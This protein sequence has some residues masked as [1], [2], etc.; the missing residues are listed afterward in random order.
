MHTI[1]IATSLADACLH[2]GDFAAFCSACVR[3]SLEYC[4][5]EGYH[6]L[7]AHM[8]IRENP[9]VKIFFSI[10]PYITNAGT[11]KQQG[12]STVFKILGVSLEQHETPNTVNSFAS[13]TE[14]S[15]KSARISPVPP[16]LSHTTPNILSCISSSGDNRIQHALV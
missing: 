15:H 4:I 14:T 9:S 16:I 8:G 11:S 12:S 3:E 10:K 2:E 13:S 7:E 5:K 6:H 1:K